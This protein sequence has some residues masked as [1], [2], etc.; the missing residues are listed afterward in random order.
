MKKREKSLIEDW[1]NYPCNEEFFCLKLEKKNLKLK[2][3]MKKIM[4]LD[5]IS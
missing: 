3:V 4:K 2:D 1:D 5:P